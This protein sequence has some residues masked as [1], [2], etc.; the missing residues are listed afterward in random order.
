[1]TKIKNN[2]GV[3]MKKYFIL[4]FLFLWGVLCFVFYHNYTNALTQY[5]NNQ[6]SKLLN[7]YNL[8][9]ELASSKLENTH[10]Q[11]F[12]SYYISKIL[13][14]I[15][16]K[17]LNTKK[18]KD[19]EAILDVTLSQ[20]IKNQQYPFDN[21]I[22]Y[23]K[24][25]EQIY[26]LNNKEHHKNFGKDFLRE[27]ISD[28][29]ILFE[30]LDN[31]RGN[32]IM[33]SPVYLNQ[34]IIAYEEKSISFDNFTRHFL[35]N[36]IYKISILTQNIEKT[37]E[38]KDDILCFYINLYPYN[39]NTTYTLK[40]QLKSSKLSE[41]KATLSREIFYS[42]LILLIFFYMFYGRFKTEENLK[43][44]G[45]FMESSNDELI[46]INL[47]NDLIEYANTTFLNNILY[48]KK[49]IKGKKIDFFIKENYL[50]EYK[51]NLRDKKS[52][53]KLMFTRKDDTNYYVDLTI[54]R[55]DEN[56]KIYMCIAKDISKE[57]YLDNKISLQKE[58][59]KTIIDASPSGIFVKNDKHEYILANDSM[60]YIFDLLSKDELIGKRDENLALADNY[61]RSLYQKE[62]QALNSGQVVS[63][64]IQKIK[65][66]YYKII[67]VP[68]ENYAY[69]IKEKMILG[70]V[71]D[72]SSEVNKKNE[73]AKINTKL[74]MEILDEIKDKINIDEKFRTIFNNIH[75]AMFVYNM[76][77]E[78]FLSELISK[79]KTA[80]EFLQTYNFKKKD[81]NKIFDRVNFDYDSKTKRYTKTHLTY[82]KKLK[83]KD[84]EH[85]VKIDAQLIEIAKEY[86]VII[87]VQNIDEKVKL[88]KEK[89]EQQ[90]L[91]A[92][93]FKKAKAGI[94]I[95]DR[96]G[97][98][99]KYNQ[100]FYRS[101]GYKRAEFGK[102]NFFSIS[103][104]EI[105]EEMRNE[106]EEIF[107][108][109]EEISHEYTFV[110]I[111]NKEVNV[112]ASSS[113]IKDGAGET[114]RLFIFEDITKLKELELEQIKNSK[115]IAQQAKMA[116][117]GEM[118]GAIAHQWRQPL[119]AINA[120]AMNL[121]FA[122]RL[123]MLEQEELIEKTQFIE[124]QSVKMSE[125][126]NDFMNF[127]KPSKDKSD[128]SLEDIYNNINEFINP[129]LKSRDIEI[130]LEDTQKITMNGF[131]NE[132]EHIMLN[133]VNNAKD[134]FENSNEDK[135][136]IKVIGKMKD[137]KVTIQVLDNAGGIPNSILNKIFNPYFT[138]K[139]QGKGTGIGLYMTK[140]IIEQHFNGTIDASN[141]DDG[142]IFTITLNQEAKE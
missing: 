129:Q 131:K 109:K 63:K 25:G 139:E 28:N 135:K 87:F 40:F 31:Q 3:V 116:E 23:N 48:T 98:L 118:I 142:A 35:H 41:L 38:F 132:F 90:M 61:C 108:T 12:S 16:N 127:F 80:N 1:M 82:I 49:E 4:I 27:I 11:N 70:F 106:H 15:N 112:F 120:A 119:N 104:K 130:S 18:N 57:K 5:N 67:L 75:D 78:G 52:S 44:V 102:Q 9:I 53:F 2:N 96:D 8:A 115:I 83:V 94:S 62:I 114:F 34:K 14:E 36:D 30:A 47:K 85:S 66:K 100:S 88:K 59:F 111:D 64:D 128:F 141:N 123:D 39:K 60:A 91:L 86:K 33:I 46:I 56:E 105:E 125:T 54:K 6:Y 21:I 136:Y 97:K 20:K 19:L 103:P 140:T 92:N 138:T 126:I 74:K 81:P 124:K 101:L 10:L 72:I 7:N 17:D 71:T 55:I 37:M 133:L 89:R 22:F 113:L 73:L 77:N 65:D 50:S 32:F 26:T 43:K 42:F 51:N 121:N 93:I 68:L 29:N 117:M 69:P 79:N 13:S 137:N 84:I 76:D 24:N 110:S 95:I 134:A 122:S 107:N 45:N 58:F 99:I